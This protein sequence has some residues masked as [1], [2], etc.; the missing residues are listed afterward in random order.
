MKKTFKIYTLEEYVEFAQFINGLSKQGKKFIVTPHLK[1]Q[2]QN[3]GFVVW[4]YN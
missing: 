4:Y 1:T 2:N 3:G